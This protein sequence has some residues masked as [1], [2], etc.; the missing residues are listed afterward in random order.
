[1][2]LT[3]T[4]WLVIVG[5]LLANLLIGIY[6]RR[7]ASG[8][9]E[10]FFISGR[11]V[12]WWLAGTSMVATTFAADTPLLVCAL[13][14]A[15]GDPDGWATGGNPLW[16]QAGG[17]SARVQ[18]DLSGTV[19]E[20]LHP[21]LGDAGHGEHYYGAAGAGD[22]GGQ[23]AGVGQAALHSGR[24]P[25]DRAADL[26]VRPDSLHRF[27]YVHRRTVGRTGDGPVP[28]RAED[29]DDHCAGLGGGGE[30]RGHAGP[31]I[32]S[33]GGGGEH[34]A[35]RR[36]DRRPDRIS[37]RFQPRAHGGRAVDAARAHLHRVSGDAVV[38]GM[39]PGSGA[40]RGRLRGAAHVQRQGR[41]ELPGRDALVQHRALC[42]A[43]VAVDHHGTGGAGRVLAAWRA[44]SERGLRAESRAGI[45]DGAARL[46][47]ACAAR[48]DGGGVPGGVHVDDRDAAELGEFVPGE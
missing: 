34:A 28:V 13:L 20:L 31:A 7:R 39:V 2:P 27:I 15:G 12:S 37:A 41:E 25:L 14:A 47:S 16:R 45:R 1:M 38:A 23:G 17:L 42:A 11:D 33:A 22:R 26:R 3:L 5:Y 4:D 44:A 9:T 35:E 46:P 8:N 48:A 43:A 36:A 21:G 6:Y 29:G 32:A 18:G 10:E 40:G 19:H 24:S 30:D